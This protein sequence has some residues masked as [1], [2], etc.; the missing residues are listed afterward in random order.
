MN[1]KD[2]GKRQLRGLG[3]ATRDRAVASQRETKMIKRGVAIGR[4]MLTTACVRSAA[5]A[6][7]N[8]SANGFRFA[9]L[10]ALVS[11]LPTKA[12]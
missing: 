1:G 11:A 4:A 8:T 7:A 2:Y 12:R 9:A 6:D 5:T 10:K 3:V